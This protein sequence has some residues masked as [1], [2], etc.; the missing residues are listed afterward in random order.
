MDGTMGG[1]DWPTIR[2]QYG[3]VNFSTEGNGIESRKKIFLKGLLA[4]LLL[5][6]LG[7]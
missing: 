5:A 1:G 2:S 6:L 4:K 3:S 7:L